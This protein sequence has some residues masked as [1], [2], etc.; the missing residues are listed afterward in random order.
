MIKK[1]KFFVKEVGLRLR[2]IMEKDCLFCKII[3][4]EIKAKSVLE[5]ENVLAFFDVNPVCDIH[6]LVIPKRHID[7]VLTISEE[8]SKEILEMY[9]AVKQIVEK[10]NIDAF[11]LTINGGKFQHVPHLHMHLLSGKKIDWNKL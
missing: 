7:S 4:G 11:R 10:K 3:A 1:A 2:Y 5:T 8:N 9:S 6:I